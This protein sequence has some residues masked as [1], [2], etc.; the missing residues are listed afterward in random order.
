M[1]AAMSASASWARASTSRDVERATACS[2]SDGPCR[3]DVL[4]FGNVI[5]ARVPAVEVRG[6]VAVVTGAASGI[7]LALARSFAADGAHVVMAD[8]HADVLA[9]E[10]SALG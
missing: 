10:A 2:A 1:P 8:I 9:E 7:G 4:D 6:K 3:N 5:P